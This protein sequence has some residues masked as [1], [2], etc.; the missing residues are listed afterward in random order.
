MSLPAIKEESGTVRGNGKAL[1]LRMPS[2]D[3]QVLAGHLEGR[4]AALKGVERC[5]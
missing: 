5:G 3:I 4:D 1:V 2:L